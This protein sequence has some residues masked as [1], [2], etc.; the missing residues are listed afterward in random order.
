MKAFIEKVL[1][2]NSS[3][4]SVDMFRSEDKKT[5]EIIVQFNDGNQLKQNF[6]NNWYTLKGYTSLRRNCLQ[7]KV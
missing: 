3:V 1:K 4:F 7:I 5:C 2:N 6:T